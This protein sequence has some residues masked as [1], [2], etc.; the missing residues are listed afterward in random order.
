MAPATDR[1]FQ[2]WHRRPAC[3]S[4]CFFQRWHP[5]RAGVVGLYFRGWHTPRA[6]ASGQLS[7]G[8]RGGRDFRGQF[9]FNAFFP[10]LLQ[11]FKNLRLKGGGDRV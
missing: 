6:G 5:P 2:R 9:I 4:G 8:C 10:E 7:M 11:R 3:A 1:F